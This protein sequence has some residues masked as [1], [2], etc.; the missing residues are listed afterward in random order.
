MPIIKDNIIKAVKE[1]S[2][3]KDKIQEVPSISEILKEHKS[4]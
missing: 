3:I 4:F 2:E 1:E